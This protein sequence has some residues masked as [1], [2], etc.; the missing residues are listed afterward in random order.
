PPPRWPYE[1]RRDRD[2][3]ARRARCGSAQR[4]QRTE[5]DRSCQRRGLRELAVRDANSASVRAGSNGTSLERTVS[6]RWD[7]FA[8]VGSLSA[9]EWRTV[10]SLLHEAERAGAGAR[11]RAR[12]S[13]A[14]CTGLGPRG[15][16]SLRLRWEFQ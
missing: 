11:F 10:S 1:R 15:A 6:S 8:S 2:P 13:H 14:A 9:P 12:L 5:L 16:W 7:P 4:V 3:R